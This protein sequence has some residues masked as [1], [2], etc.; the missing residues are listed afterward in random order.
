[1]PLWAEWTFMCL[2]GTIS[3]ILLSGLAALCFH[4]LSIPREAAGNIVIAWFGFRF[5]VSMGLMTREKEMKTWE[6]VICLSGIVFT[7]MW[8]ITTAMCM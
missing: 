2:L 8:A 4:A 5:L 3:L 6:E 7:P 1:M